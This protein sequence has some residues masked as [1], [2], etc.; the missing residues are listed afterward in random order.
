M[1]RIWPYLFHPC[2]LKDISSGRD[3]YER[4]Q[5]RYL[6]SDKQEDHVERHHAEEP[7]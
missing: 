4:V 5:I 3:Y 6:K 2:Y 1:H 7:P